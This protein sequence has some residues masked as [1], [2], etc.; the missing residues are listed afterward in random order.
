[1]ALKSP[2]IMVELEEV[3]LYSIVFRRMYP[4]MYS[5]G[6][7]CWF[8][9][10]RYLC[11]LSHKLCSELPVPIEPGQYVEMSRISVSPMRK[12][13][14]A[15]TAHPEGSQNVRIG[16]A[17]RGLLISICPPT[18]AVSVRPSYVVVKISMVEPDPNR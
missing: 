11:S 13:M 12:S 8:R 10:H 6:V 16:H 5:S 2:P 18:F 15:T 17:I 4:W 3:V 1:M 7:I 14:P 9:E